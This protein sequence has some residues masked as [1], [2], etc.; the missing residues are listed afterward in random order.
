LIGFSGKHHRQPVL[1]S[2]GAYAVAHR[3]LYGAVAGLVPGRAAG[4]QEA[5]EK[6][7]L[8]AAAKPRFTESAAAAT[9]RV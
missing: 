6:Q 3:K 5:P 8:E 1:G 9:T 2:V 7:R 4:A